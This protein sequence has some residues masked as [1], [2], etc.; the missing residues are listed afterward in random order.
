MKYRPRRNTMPLRAWIE[1]VPQ[2]Y[3]GRN[4]DPEIRGLMMIAALAEVTTRYEDRLRF[5]EDLVALAT[6]E[7][8]ADMPMKEF[9]GWLTRALAMRPTFLQAVED[10]RTQYEPF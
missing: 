7:D 6:S 10:Y 3:G 9:H 2:T 1:Q 8:T 5:I 4:E